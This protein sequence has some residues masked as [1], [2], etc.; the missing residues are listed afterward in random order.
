MKS[1]YIS[2][3]LNISGKGDDFIHK[4]SKPVTLDELR[5]VEGKRASFTIAYTI[6]GEESGLDNILIGMIQRSSK[7]RGAE[8]FGLPGGTRMQDELESDGRIEG[9]GSDETPEIC[10]ARELAEETNGI[11]APSPNDLIRIT[12]GY[13][14]PYT[15]KAHPA[16]INLHLYRL[17]PEEVSRITETNE[18]IMSDREFAKQFEKKTGEVR[19]I[20]LLPVSKVLRLDHYVPQ[21]IRDIRTAVKAIYMSEFN[22]TPL[23]NN[24]FN[25]ALK[26]FVPYLSHFNRANQPIVAKK[27]QTMKSFMQ[28]IGRIS[29]EK[30]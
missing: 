22:K 9:K 14:N 25:S 26:D 11:I 20:T 24:D 7:V 2:Q 30:E 28:S 16:R 1:Q 29:A 19:R 5:S 6:V 8:K 17:S 18:K 15:N 23:R 27:G 10:A 21:T 12:P 13:L 4:T 3:I